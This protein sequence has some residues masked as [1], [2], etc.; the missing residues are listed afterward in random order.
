M[1]IV[2]DKVI[3][4]HKKSYLVNFENFNYE[5]DSF[6]YEKNEDTKKWKFSKLTKHGFLWS[7]E[8]ISEEPDFDEN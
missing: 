3:L 8:L 5:K 6:K 4:E 2:S 7:Y 1:L